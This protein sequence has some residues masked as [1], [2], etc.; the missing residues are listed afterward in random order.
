MT[1]WLGEADDWGDDAEEE[2]QEDPNG[3]FGLGGGT[4]VTADSQ[5]RPQSHTNIVVPLQ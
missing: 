2:E 1:D 4:E 3:N 5:S